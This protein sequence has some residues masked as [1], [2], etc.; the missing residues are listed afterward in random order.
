MSLI[1]DEE[2]E[3]K[4]YTATTHGCLRFSASTISDLVSDSYS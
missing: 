4:S 2:H 3:E 1:T